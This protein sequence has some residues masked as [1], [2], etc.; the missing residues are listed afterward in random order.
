MNIFKQYAILMDTQ[1]NIAYNIIKPY[2]TWNENKIK[3]INLLHANKELNLKFEQRT[4]FKHL[5]YQ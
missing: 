3:I 2:G 4:H 1:T 5:D